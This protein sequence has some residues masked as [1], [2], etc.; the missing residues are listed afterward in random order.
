MNLVVGR[1]KNG[2]RVKCGHP[3]CTRTHQAEGSN[4]S[5]EHFFHP[6]PSY[7]SSKCLYED[8]NIQAG[9]DSSSW[10][11]AHTRRLYRKR[12]GQRDY[13][14]Y[15]AIC[16]THWSVRFSVT[17]SLTTLVENFKSELLT[18]RDGVF[19]RGQQLHPLMPPLFVP[20]PVAEPVTVTPNHAPERP[21]LVVGEI[22]RWVPDGGFSAVETQFA[23]QL[24]RLEQIESRVL[25]VHFS[26]DGGITYDHHGVVNRE[27]LV[28]A[29]E[30]SVEEA[31]T[32]VEMVAGR[33]YIW[34]PGPHGLM[35]IPDEYIGQ[36]GVLAIVNNEG[37]IGNLRFVD[38]T[39]WTVWQEA[40]TPEPPA[41]LVE[42]QIYRWVPNGEFRG[43][44]P[45]HANQLC[46]ITTVGHDLA[47]VRFS[48]DDGI[49]YN[50]CHAVR[51]DQLVYAGEVPA[52]DT[53]IEFPPI[54]PFVDPLF[55][56]NAPGRRRQPE[57]REDESND[58]YDDREEEDGDED[59]ELPDATPREQIR[60]ALFGGQP[61]PNNVTLLSVWKHQKSKSL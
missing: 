10:L 42:D 15:V 29:G 9:R 45:E 27:Q 25:G 19:Q 59:W 18:N 2:N 3:G 50:I 20:E 32:P 4:S 8:D 56:P 34:R 30:V 14:P 17:P 6:N 11:I 35:G 39:I 13:T 43:T 37:N 46:R 40:L 49:T 61:T 57:P 24:C 58:D 41:R 44:P 5:A 21:T 53:T 33:R 47:G 31:P 26:T 22:Y 38:D 12:R 1:L 52:G 23:N 60:D 48:R 51:A 55:N 16:P 7:Y 28:Y 36:I 54:A